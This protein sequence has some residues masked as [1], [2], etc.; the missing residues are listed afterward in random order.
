MLTTTE[1]GRVYDTLLCI[2]G[3]NET[4]KIDLRI[5]R[6][7]VL[8]LTQVIQRGISF[9]EG[10]QVQGLLDTVNPE[11]I[12]ELEELSIDCLTKAGLMELNEKLQKL[13]VK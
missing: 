4:V 8:L 5:S 2:P 13:Q 6:T 7:M 1:L 3:M 12:R 10:E 9:K 11:T